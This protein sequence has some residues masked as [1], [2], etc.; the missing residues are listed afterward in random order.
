MI[1]TGWSRLESVSLGRILRSLPSGKHSYM[2]ERVLVLSESVR[3]IFLTAI[4]I[5]SIQV[6]VMLKAGSTW[7]A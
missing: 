6:D 1:F 4:L 3:L 7:K 5:R 2:V